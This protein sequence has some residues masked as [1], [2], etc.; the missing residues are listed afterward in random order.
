MSAQ[1]L[2]VVSP[3]RRSEGINTIGKYFKG[4]HNTTMRAKSRFGSNM[5]I[6]A[7]PDLRLDED[8]ADALA[9]GF[10]KAATFRLTSK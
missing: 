5:V 6:R 4:Q 2:M 7:G 8:I 1:C 9:A 10:A 3:A